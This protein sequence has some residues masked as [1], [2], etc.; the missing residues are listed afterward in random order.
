VLVEN[1][2]IDELAI[3]MVKLMKNPETR[4]EMANRAVQNVH[5]YEIGQIA[6]LWKSLFVSL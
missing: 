4:I 3:N 1:G 6:M 2:N 5:R